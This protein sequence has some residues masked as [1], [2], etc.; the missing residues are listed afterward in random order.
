MDNTTRQGDE[1]CQKHIKYEYTCKD[2]E[3]N[4][5]VVCNINKFLK[6]NNQRKSAGENFRTKT[7][8]IFC[9]KT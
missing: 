9:N 7:P 4:I 5:I 6:Q 2:V 1:A 8:V 3:Q